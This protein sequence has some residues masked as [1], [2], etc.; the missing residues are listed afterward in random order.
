MSTSRARASNKATAVFAQGDAVIR[1][2]KI[3]AVLRFPLVNTLS[4]TLSALLYSFAAEY[5][6]GD[7][8]KV[9]R[10]LDQWWQ[11]S[12]LVGW[13]TFELG[14][15]WFGDY[16]GYDLVSLSLLSHGPPLYLL[17]SFYEISPASVISSL[18]IDSL[19]TYIPFRL[20]RPLSLAHSASSSKY[21]VSVRNKD[22]ITSNSIQAY[23]VILGGAIYAVTLFTSYSTF[24]PVYLVTYFDGIHSIAA[25]HASS[26]IAL[27]PTTFLLGLAAK[28]FIFT[29]TVTAAPTTE[30]AKNAAFH[31]ETATFGETFW[32]NVWGYS[33]RKKVVIKRTATLMLAT[34]INTFV[35]TFVTIE[36][37]EAAGAVVYSGVWVAAALITGLTLGVV[38]DV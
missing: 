38:A 12:V 19:T 16:D 32:Y 10:T 24:L 34:G 11:V 1:P 23:T 29:P 15:G 6:S 27:F 28:S 25:A 35:Q 33:S 31:P 5:T 14:L 18:V 7:L 20:L 37:V 13:R 26:P 3:P 8:A 36:G 9:S 4:L 21:S 2:S 22:I 30:D 17:G